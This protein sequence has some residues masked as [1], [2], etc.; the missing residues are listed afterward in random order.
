MNPRLGFFLLKDSPAM[1]F[2]VILFDLHHTLTRTRESPNSMLRR[3]AEESG[4]DLSTRSDSDLTLAYAKSNEWL[5][6]YQLENNVGPDWGAEAE[7]WIEADRVMFE[8]LGVGGLGEET[9]LEIER[10]WKREVRSGAWESLHSEAE[11]VLSQLRSRG[12]TLGLCTRRYD[13][14]AQ[15]L[16]IFGIRHLFSVVTYSGVPGYAKPSPYTLFRAAEELQ[17]NPRLCAYVGNDA[18]VDTE[19]ARRA[20]MHSVLLLWADP[21]GDRAVPSD[22]T[23]L[24]SLGDLLRFFPGA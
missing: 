17:T 1:R 22:V 20:G 14:P 6:R 4:I 18:R 13:D 10:R 7:Q 2:N 5:L 8:H 3:V 15:L 16:E 19:A 21:N 11:Q 9:I 24:G 12:Y 23:V